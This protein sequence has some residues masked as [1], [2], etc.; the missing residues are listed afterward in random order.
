M[1]TRRFPQ[2]GDS[3]A[4]RRSQAQVPPSSRLTP[5]PGRLN[6]LILASLSIDPSKRPAGMFEIRDQLSAIAKQMGL[7]EVDLRGA[8]E[9]D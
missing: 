9:E 5:H 2:Q 7:A 1:F 6:E 3:Q 4:G 8:E